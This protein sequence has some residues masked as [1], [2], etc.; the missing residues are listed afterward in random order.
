ME[1]ERYQALVCVMETGSLSAAA[2]RLHYTASGISRMM[3][4][5]ES[6]VGF[7]LLVRRHEG[8][9]P[10]PECESLLPAI[11]GFIA[12]GE[13]CRQHA[14]RIRGLEIGSVTVGTAYSEYYGLLSDVIAEFR[15]EHPGIVVQLVGGYSSQLAGMM[16]Q[17]RLD[18][19]IISRREGDFAWKTLFSDELVAWIPAEPMMSCLRKVVYTKK[20]GR[21]I[22]Q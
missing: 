10:T 19:C 16:E 20:C 1:L 13:A 21:H 3:A 8:V 14:A 22:Y 4:A 18:L 2:E 11:R 9:L 15:R 12:A 5:L 17:R 7:P 6:E